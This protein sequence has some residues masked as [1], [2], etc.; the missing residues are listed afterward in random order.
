LY[1]ETQAELSAVLCRELASRPVEREEVVRYLY[2][3]QTERISLR[4]YTNFILMSLAY[5]TR[6]HR[7]SPETVDYW[8]HGF[9]SYMTP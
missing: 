2:N 5:L 6:D 7:R 9:E 1:F 8:D 4:V 3:D